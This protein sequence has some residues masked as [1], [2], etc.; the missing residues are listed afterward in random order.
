M[1]WF[2]FYDILIFSRTYEEHLIHVL[3][4]L[5]LLHRDKWQVKMSKCLFAQR[6]LRYLGHIIS[7]AGVAT[8]PKKIAAVLQWP[9]STSVKELCSFLRLAGYYRRFFRHFRVIWKP[10]T[11]LLRK[12]AIFVWTDVQE[13]A[14]Q[15][16]KQA[17]ASAPV[18]VLPD[19]SK[20]F[21][22]ETDASGHGIGAVLMQGGH[23]LA[24]LSKALGPRS[25]GLSTYEKEYMAILMALEQWRSYFQH[26]EFH[27]ITDHRSL[28]QLTEQRLQPVATKGVYQAYWSAVFFFSI[29]HI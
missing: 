19:F 9:S 13:Q 8:D 20:P 23:P 21:Q 26:A 2:F 27:I 11:E 14:F 18:L 1:F 10:L 12:G 29:R 22:V 16:L 3:Q 28:V 4:V 7:E 17:L 15:T 24:F 5:E 25:M 6:Q